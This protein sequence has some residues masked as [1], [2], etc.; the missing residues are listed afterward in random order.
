M[1][2]GVDVNVLASGTAAEVRR[3]TRDIL[4][5]CVPGG[6]YALGSGNSIADY[7]PPENYKA[8]IEE[9]LNWEG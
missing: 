3:Y 2:G 7:I 5:R 1:L 8:M 6:G 4:A 9:G